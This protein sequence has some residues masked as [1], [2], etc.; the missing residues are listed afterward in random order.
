MTP[1]SVEPIGTYYE[2]LG[3]DPDAPTPVIRDAYRRAARAH[4]PDRHGEQASAR[5][6]E[7]NRAWQTLADPVRRRD[8]DLGLSTPTSTTTS[9]AT[10]T[11]H[12]TPEPPQ[13]LPPARFP[14]RFMG[15]LFLLGVGL[16]ILG[17]LTASDPVAPTV[18]NVLQQGDCV[19]IEANGDASERLCTEPHDGVVEQLVPFG[20][21]CA[22]TAEPHRD[23][24]GMG[25]ACVRIG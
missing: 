2:L 22:A 19:V 20:S 11:R 17:V 3:V 16:V 5:M 18:D 9:R 1:R 12:V 7:I 21:P 14:W 23:Q 8:Y 10:T 24:Q 4:H 13:V 6:A 25:T 15:V